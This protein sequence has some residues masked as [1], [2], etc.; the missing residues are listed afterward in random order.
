MRKVSSRSRNVA[1][2]RQGWKNPE[3]GATARTQRQRRLMFALRGVFLLALMTVVSSS[4]G[5]TGGPPVVDGAMAPALGVQS[6]DP[7]AAYNT[8]D[9]VDYGGALY[10][11]AAPSSDVVPGT[12]AGIWTALNPASGAPGGSSDLS[13][14][15]P[16]VNCVTAG[17]SVV[18]GYRN[19]GSATVIAPI[20]PTNEVSGGPAGRGQPIAFQPGEH[21]AA[22]VLD[23]PLNSGDRS[24]LSWTLGTRTAIVPGAPPQCAT[25]NGPDGLVATVNGTS[26]LTHPDPASIV[27]AGVWSTEGRSVV[28]ATPG[29]FQVSGDGAAT[30][31]MPLWTPPALMG[32]G[33]RLSLS[34]SSGAGR[35]LLGVGWN[36]TGFG[37]SRITRCRKTVAED[38]DAT[39]VT[40][41]DAQDAFCL[42]GQRMLPT[43]DPAVNGKTVYQ[44]ERDPFTRILFDPTAESFEVDR[45]D[46]WVLTYGTSF[47]SRL[48][49]TPTVWVPGPNGPQHGNSPDFTAVY[50]WGLDAAR[51]PSGNTM[52]VAY[53]IFVDDQEALAPDYCSEL[54]P[55]SIS[56][57]TGPSSPQPLRSVTFS[58]EKPTSPEPSCT[59]VGGFPL[60]GQA[61]IHQIAMSGPGAT[62][63]PSVLRAYTMT[64][65]Q[66][67]ATGHSLLTA[68]QECDGAVNCKAPTTFAYNTALAPMQLPAAQFTEVVHAMDAPYSMA[69]MASPNDFRF[70]DL[71]GDGKDD[72]L[73]TVYEQYTIG[74]YPVETP[75]YTPYYFHYAYALSDGVAFQAPQIYAT[76][77]LNQGV[78]RPPNP[79]YLTELDYG[80]KPQFMLGSAALTFDLNSPS[81]G[82]DYAWRGGVAEPYFVGDFDGNGEADLIGVENGGSR[83]RYW[84]GGSS[85]L[86]FQP[87]FG[88]PSSGLP[89]MTAARMSDGVGDLVTPETF[90]TRFE[91][92]APIDG[93]G[94]T[95]FLSH[96]TVTDAGG[97]QSASPNLFATWANAATGALTSQETTL[98]SGPGWVT[99]P[100]P[101]PI[102][103][104]I[105]SG[106]AGL[107][108][109]C[110][111]LR[112]Y[113]QNAFH[114]IFLDINGDGNADAIQVPN[115]GGTP[116][117]IAFN[118]GAGFGPLEPLPGLMPA[119]SSAYLFPAIGQDATSAPPVPGI[120]L[121][122]D[123]NGD[124][125]QDLLVAN[126]VNAT[127]ANNGPA[128]GGLVAYISNGGAGL[129]GVGLVDQGGDPIK[130]G[131][132]DPS[133]W[134]PG[135]CDPSPCAM[136][137]GIAVLDFDGDGV[138][139]IFSNGHIYL[140]SREKPDLLTDV[141]D[142]LGNST[143]TITY[144]A[145]GKNSNVVSATGAPLYTPATDCQYPLQCVVKGS[146]VVSSYQLTGDASYSSW[147]S[148]VTSAAPLTTIAYDYA[149]GRI[150]VRGRGWLGFSHFDVV[151]LA[152]GARTST[153]YFDPGTDTGYGYPFAGAVEVVATTAATTAPTVPP[154][155]TPTERTET[156][157]MNYDVIPTLG[158]RGAVLRPHS[159]TTHGQ[160]I[161]GGYSVDLSSTSTVYGYDSTTAPFNANARSTT[162]NLSGETR[163]WGATYTQNTS[164]GKWLL[165]M[166]TSTTETS[167]V[168]NQLPVT[169]THAYDPDPA[170]GLVKDET[171]EPGGT[172]DVTSYTEYDYLPNGQ[173]SHVGVTAVDP[174][175][176]APIARDQWFVYD[177]FDGIFPSATM[178]GLGQTTRTVYHPGL[179]ALL[180][181]EDPNGVKAHTIVDLF[182]RPVELLRDGVVGGTTI[183]YEPGHPYSEAGTVPGLVTVETEF[184]GGGH[185]LV[186]FNSLGHEVVRGA[187]NHDGTFSYVET[188]YTGVMP[189]QVASVS[190]PHAYNASAPSEYNSVLTYDLLG[191]VLSAT[192]PDYSAVKTSYVGAA[193]TVTDGRGYATTTIRD[194]LGRATQVDEDSQQNP[195]YSSAALYQTPGTAVSTHYAY[196][197][198]DVLNTVSVQARASTGGATTVLKSVTCDVLGRRL[199][200]VDADSG[201]TETTYDALGETTSETDANG[202]VHIPSYD[203]IGR[204]IANYSNREGATFFQWDTAP[205]G[206]GKLASATSPD[207]VTTSYT[208]DPS[209]G[210][211]RSRTWNI[212]KY[213]A[214]TLATAPDSY[215][216]VTSLTYPDG[217][218]ATF[219]YD[220][221]GCGE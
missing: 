138:T 187:L 142:G 42:D 194:D 87:T 68:V 119:S 133:A 177:S 45:R 184:A 32:V 162:S 63:T 135:G 134:S 110:A 3:A 202:N 5:D 103:A 95:A 21:D 160:E 185:T 151:N 69:N 197:P 128:G 100:S 66:S 31:N 2:H 99:V 198:F 122:A 53:E 178:N 74:P 88:G 16:L 212:P 44:T 176:S 171:V 154:G 114:Y 72:V 175:T 179:G 170:T 186:T 143:K 163:T 189:G 38:G 221:A 214:F 193:T 127:D 191:R 59:Y 109:P 207:N 208:Y 35:G 85:V 14:L 83:W 157:L 181:A 218:Q 199:S 58:Y 129:Q 98:P 79:A 51:D 7:T 18:M 50:A 158:G 36:L 152:T 150:D 34:Y 107:T 220:A 104:V 86:G 206:V 117:G 203:A 156:T 141:A 37:I 132:G 20:G 30:Y 19:A 105:P 12:N 124:G 75:G 196:G 113:V 8:G 190:N 26:I 56:Y 9:V 40:F 183:A 102:C 204:R 91:Y 145:L 46:G 144:A 216:R 80:L 81:L 4:R 84:L 27:N 159:V 167:A 62:S 11:A 164:G 130:Q 73:F 168:P 71:N 205:N 94:R 65:G 92:V 76:T 125:L 118:T 146:W 155:P 112:T 41:V 55:Q 28:G 6:W 90:P 17:G 24:L 54:L 96:R 101:V 67:A 57:T 131:G 49:D 1:G 33:P 173:V 39:P 149:G 211:P 139:D 116:L 25:M 148:G 200:L 29:T 201:Q 219:G 210:F 165:G 120:V 192:L 161:A 169:R 123:I 77:D 10:Q 106:A 140:G 48:A 153:D 23:F 188:A 215:G 93:T 126:N 52:T 15:T 182:G 180:F 13:G 115:E 89:F 82:A 195:T 78:P 166:L 70:V 136:P 172:A 137:F 64:Y 47:R 22:F 121:A 174:L 217:T 43:G 60:G 213:G 61:R 111:P 209:S 147:N 97:T 108:G